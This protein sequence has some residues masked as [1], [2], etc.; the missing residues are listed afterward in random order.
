[1]TISLGRRLP[2]GSSGVP[3]S[4][5]GRVNGTCFALHRTGFGEP[6]CHHGAGGLLP[7]RFTL[8]EA[9]A[10]AVSFLCHCPSA[11]AVWGFPSVLPYG[12][13]TFLARAAEAACPRSPGL[14]EGG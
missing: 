1:M 12:V 2:D 11:F 7:H 3:G 8:T 13:R 4:S 14:R 9:E 10:P 5:A 6:P